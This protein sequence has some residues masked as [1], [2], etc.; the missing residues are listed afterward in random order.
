[1]ILGRDDPNLAFY[2]FQDRDLEIGFYVDRPKKL[3]VI[4]SI[5][6]AQRGH[7]GD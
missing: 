3:I 2:R 1:V 7:Y 5:S 4:T 6:T